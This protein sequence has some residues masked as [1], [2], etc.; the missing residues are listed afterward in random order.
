MTDRDSSPI[1]DPSALLSQ[2][3]VKALKFAVIAMGVLIFVGLAVVV[4][5]IIYLASGSST[6]EPLAAS[7]VAA[8]GQV[9][10]PMGARVKQMTMTNDRLVLHYESNANAGLV[11]LDLKTA[12][13]ISHIEIETRGPNQSK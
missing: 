6:S 1:H 7:A 9:S 2:T 12:R 13:Q 3:H 10:L 4:G 5:R 11:I 8:D